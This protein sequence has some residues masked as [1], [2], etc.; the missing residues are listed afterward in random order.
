MMFAAGIG[1]G[2]LFFGVL[3]PVYYN[4]VEGEAVNSLGIGVAE[5]KYIGIVGNIHHLGLEGRTVYA[6]VGLSLGIFSYNLGY[7]LTL[8]SAFVPILGERVWGA[9]GRAIETAAVFAT[10]N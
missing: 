8:R 3:E 7:P 5:N 6:A 10:L 2:L 9:W 1:I 4:F